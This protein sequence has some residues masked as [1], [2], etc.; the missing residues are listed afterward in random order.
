MYK[1]LSAQSLG[2]GQWKMTEIEVNPLLSAQSLGFGLWYNRHPELSL[3]SKLA[4]FQIP[5]D[6]SLSPQIQFAI[7]K[8]AFHQFVGVRQRLVSVN[9]VDHVVDLLKN[10]RKILILSGAGVSTSCG[11][12]DFR[13]EAGIYSR[14]SEFNLSDPQGM[15][16]SINVEEMFDLRYFRESP[17][18]FYSFAK[19]IYPA[20][21]IIEAYELEF[22]PVENS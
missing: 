17:E 13:S 8:R 7:L 9:T 21:C 18:T 14:L 20:V 1:N 11:I 16:E 19:E 12:P 2:S 22:H 4:L 5:C 6:E 3:S 15:S 10:S